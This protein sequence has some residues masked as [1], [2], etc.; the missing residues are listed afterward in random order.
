MIVKPPLKWVGGKTQILPAVLERFPPVIENYYEPF[1]GG[2]S[3]L[4]GLLSQRRH[5]VRGAVYASDANPFLIGFYVNLQQRPRELIAE[6][7]KFID[8]MHACPVDGPVDRAP[9]D[10]I[11]GTS[12]PES[13]YYWV[14]SHMNRL[15]DKSSLRASA[16][17]MFI[18]KTCF[19]GLYRTGPNGFNVPYGHYKNPSIMDTSHMLEVS[20]LIKDVQF[21]CGD[22]AAVFSAA[23]AGDFVYLDPPYVP[24]K[25]SSFVSYNADGFGLEAHKIL[26]KA[27]RDTPARVLMSNA[28][29]PLIRSELPSPPFMITTLAARRAINSKEP[30]SVT[31]EVLVRNYMA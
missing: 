13:F 16:M 24:E 2:G 10:N 9:A 14:R 21:R 27:M 19:R 29:V 3:V 1:L 7:Q 4:L 31:Q 28:D 6:V 17:F 25:A 20:A 8:Q 30:D 22:Y 5:T 23:A 18:N 12:S 11:T 15:E 26:F